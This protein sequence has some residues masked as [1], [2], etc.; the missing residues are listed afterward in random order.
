MS[1][2]GQGSEYYITV[3]SN[4]GRLYQVEYAFKA[5][6]SCGLTSIGIRGRDCVV[7]LAEK[8]VQVPLNLSRTVSLTPKQ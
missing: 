4:E 8:K 3:F 1:K 6:K 2:S 7:L 5:V